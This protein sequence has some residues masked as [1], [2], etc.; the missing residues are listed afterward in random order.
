MQEF[1]AVLTAAFAQAEEL[2]LITDSEGGIQCVN[3]A[4][5][6]LTGCTRPDAPGLRF[7]SVSNEW[8]RESLWVRLFQ[9]LDEKKEWSGEIEGA[10]SDGSFK[11]VHLLIKPFFDPHG[12]ITHLVATGRD[13]TVETRLQRQLR[14]AQKMEALGTLAGGI[15]HDFN[16]ILAGVIGHAE[17]ASLKA[18][19]PVSVRHHIEQVLNAGNRAKSLVKQI[20]AFSRQTD[21]ESCPVQVA[22]IIKEAL[23]LLRASLPTTIEIKQDIAPGN[24]LVLADPTQIHQLIMNLCSNAAHAMRET[25]GILEV[26][27]RE[28]DLTAADG[29]RSFDLAPGRHLQLTVSDTGHGMTRETLDRIFDPF[30][31]TKESGEGTGMGLSV[32]YSIVKSHHGAISAS[33]E[34]G[35]G[36]RFTVLLPIAIRSQPNRMEDNRPRLN[37]PGG[38][39]HILL[40]D[41]EEALVSVGREIMQ[42]LG[43]R[44]TSVTSSEKALQVF[45]E[46]PDS[47]DLVVT[48]QTMPHMTGIELAKSL[49]RTRP[50]LPIIL[51]T[52]YG[53]I[54]SS[55]TARSTGIRELLMKPYV[56]RDLASTIR[57]ILDESGD[58]GAVEHRKT[59]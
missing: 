15:A 4:L 38:S 44:V 32:V 46:K 3:P 51:C 7:G 59:V 57:R 55:E 11:R 48:D 47:F 42:H 21:Q 34:V 58:C 37:F 14:Q 33:S 16:N 52:G 6:R 19:D 56:L 13:I 22:I 27:L 31:T 12:H 29:D 49:F 35:R 26:S 23:K 45:Q 50:E 10:H 18:D 20:L 43:Y 28:I 41:D 39:E 2:I 54:V 8:S 9:K 40:V 36:S 25:G 30:F 1:Q 53:D 5:Q 17:M 24:G